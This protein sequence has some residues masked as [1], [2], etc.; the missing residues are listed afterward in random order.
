MIVTL[1][2]SNSVPFCLQGTAEKLHWIFSVPVGIIISIFGLFGN[3]LSIII[4]RR[5][6]R[7]NFGRNKSTAIYLIAL[8]VADISLLFFFLTHNTLPMLFKSLMTTM[9]YCNYFAYVGFPFFFLSIV[10]SIW[11]LVCVTF[12]RFIL[13]NF[14]IKAK[15]FCSAA[16]A[17]L[18]I[19]ITL[20]CCFIVNMPHFFSYR[21]KSVTK[22]STC[23]TLS[24]YGQSNGS[25]NYEFWVHCIFLVLAPWASIAFCNAGII[26]AMQKRAKN[27]AKKFSKHD[28]DQD[29]QMTRMLM[30]VTFTF[31]VLLAW[32]CI[33]QCFYM[34]GY[35]GKKGHR[36]NMVD[37]SFASAKLGVVIN[38]SI[39]FILYSCTGSVFRKELFAI[40]MR[41]TG[42]SY[43]PTSSSGTGTKFTNDSFV[44]SE[45]KL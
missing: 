11:L 41:Q 35:D 44:G 28:N 21:P 27:V 26:Y 3:V 4:W 32:Q 17:Y 14:P 8:A 24:E 9:S 25:I 10:A 34:L 20:T 40:F 45:S 30:A 42:A 13:V 16:R 1:R 5:I 2:L 6:L 38:S 33:T 15:A 12:N 7:K 43:K 37:Q 39:N 31:L 29:K 18:G 23:M 22:N 19:G 36:W